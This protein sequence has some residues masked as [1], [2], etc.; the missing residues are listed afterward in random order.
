MG[1]GDRRQAEAV[2][3]HSC[4]CYSDGDSRVKEASVGSFWDSLQPLGR[5]KA[6]T[7]KLP[8]PAGLLQ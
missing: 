3:L 4:K 6:S 7:Q 2:I 5:S 8:F 1:G